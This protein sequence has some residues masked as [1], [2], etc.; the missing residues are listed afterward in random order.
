M[1]LIML[2]KNFIIVPGAILLITISYYYIKNIYE[3]YKKGRKEGI[4][5]TWEECKQVVT[6]YP[7]AEYK[8]FYT[9]KEANDYLMGVD[10]PSEENLTS[11]LET[12]IPNQVVAYVDGSYDQNIMTQLKV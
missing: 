8:G 5:K 10:N 1:I 12:S 3:E 9:E 6:G 11:K 2:V 7:G 4:F